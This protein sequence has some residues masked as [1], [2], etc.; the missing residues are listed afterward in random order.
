MVV[1]KNNS[2]N[3]V[4]NSFISN[5]CSSKIWHG[6][7]LN[8]YR[9]SAA[10]SLIIKDHSQKTSQTPKFKIKST[11]IQLLPLSLTLTHTRRGRSMP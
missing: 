11:P 7:K 5:A 8:A 6:A 9:V 10:V 2:C 1:Q 4:L 3:H